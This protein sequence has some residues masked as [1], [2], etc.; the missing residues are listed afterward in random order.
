M[1]DV[2]LKNHTEFDSIQMEVLNKFK[3]FQQAIID[4]DAK[5]LNFIM[6]EDYTLTHMSGKIQTKKEYI[7]DIANGVLNYYHSTI[8]DPIIVILEEKYAKLNA[9]VELDAKVYG[10][11]GTWTLNTEILMEKNEN[12]WIL[13]RWDN[14]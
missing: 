1:S 2:S 9:D 12:I 3:E 8:I 5:T 6:S 13:S 10:I 14:N 7:E 11:K 4:K